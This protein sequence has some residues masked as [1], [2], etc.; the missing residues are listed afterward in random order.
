[1]YKN[2]YYIQAL[3]MA[4]LITACSSERSIRKGDSYA[5]VMEYHEAAKEYRKAYRK[6][7]TKEKKASR[8]GMENG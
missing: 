4:I 7:A 6:I 5:A 2:R 3:L 8:S 1:V